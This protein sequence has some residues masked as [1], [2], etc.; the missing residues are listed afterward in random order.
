MDDSLFG[1]KHGDLV[2]ATKYLER[3]SLVLKTLKLRIQTASTQLILRKHLNTDHPPREIKQGRKKGG[4]QNTQAPYQHRDK[5]NTRTP[6]RKRSRVDIHQL[7]QARSALQNPDINEEYTTVRSLRL[8]FT[9]WYTNDH[10]ILSYYV[11]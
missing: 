1:D 10:I 2:K 9:V 6:I 8:L 11:T 7:P 3:A 5:K 4:P